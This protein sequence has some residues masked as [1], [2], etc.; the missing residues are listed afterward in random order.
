MKSTAPFTNMYAFV[1]ITAFILSG[2]SDSKT[3][4]SA[5]SLRDL[6]VDH[7]DLAVFR[8]AMNALGVMEELLSGDNGQ[9]YTVFAPTD[10]AINASKWFNAYMV[11]M[12]GGNGYQGNNS[13]WHDNLR[14]SIYNHIVPNASLL[15]DELFD[16]SVGTIQSLWDPL[17]V[18][19][20]LQVVSGAAIEQRNITASNGILHTVSS[21][22]EPRFYN[23]S[24]AAL[25]LQPELGP[26]DPA[27]GLNRVSMVTIVDFVDG[28]DILDEFRPNGTTFSGCRIRALNRITLDYLFQTVNNAENPNV[29]YGEFMNE[30]RRNQ[31]R[32]ELLRYNLIP[33]NYYAGDYPDGFFELVQPVNQCGNMW[34]TKMEGRMAFNEGREVAEPAPRRFIANNG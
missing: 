3:V 30:T 15:Y 28:R 27:L 2:C 14:F 11:G 33:R 19:S 4:A 6:I 29:K 10:S 18:G 12:E 25:E 16:G 22:M 9:T 1:A 31:T 7:P 5:Q 32:D 34:I 20:F 17:E 23:N 24:F 21:V 26:D 8:T 13:I